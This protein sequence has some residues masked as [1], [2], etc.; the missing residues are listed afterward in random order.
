MDQNLAKITRHICTGKGF[1]EP[2]VGQSGMP[3]NVLEFIRKPCIS[4]LEGKV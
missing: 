3:E 1:K 4:L 2:G